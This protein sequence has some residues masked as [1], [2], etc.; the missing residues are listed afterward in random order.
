MAE[1]AR[2]AN[3]PGFRSF[4]PFPE[5]IREMSLKEAGVADADLVVACTNQ[6]EINLLTAA[7]ARVRL[8]L[9]M[10]GRLEI[11]AVLV[12]FTPRFWKGH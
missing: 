4:E 11:F 2:S 1:E 3:R 5:W 7:F 12:L 9:M 10:I 8:V 6:D